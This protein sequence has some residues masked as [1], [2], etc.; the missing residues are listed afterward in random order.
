M[1]LYSATLAILTTL[2]NPLTFLSLL[3]L[4]PG[5]DQFLFL[6][7]N[8]YVARIQDETAKTPLSF[9]SSADYGLGKGAR[10]GQGRE[11]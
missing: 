2:G 9:P 11:P 8:R 1:R 4:A 3:P 5:R 10:N 6:M 7:R